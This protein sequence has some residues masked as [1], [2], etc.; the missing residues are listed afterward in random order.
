MTI[1][2]VGE[3][4]PYGGDPAFALY[5]EPERSA[6]GR[7]CRLVLG[8]EPREYLRRFTRVNLLQRPKWSA[9]LARERAAEMLLTA[10]Q[11]RFI[12]LGRRVFDAFTSQKVGDLPKVTR[13]WVPLTVYGGNMLALPHPSGL[14]RFWNT[15][16]AFELARNAVRAFAP[17][18]LP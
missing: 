6:G 11:A 15:P 10:P 18:V 12:L 17:G 2:L 14:C 8:L 16:G 1:V 13:E 9:P 3:N 4:N 5:C 7:L